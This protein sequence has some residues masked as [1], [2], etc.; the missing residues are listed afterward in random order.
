VVF[1]FFWNFSP[2][3]GY[4]ERSYLIDVRHFSPTSF[5]IILA[6]GSLAFLVSIVVYRWVVRRFRGVAWYHYLY[7]TVAVGVLAFPASFFLYLDPDHPWWRVVWWLLPDQLDV[8]TG[9]NRYAWC[10]LLTQ[11]ILGFATIPAFLI[12]LTLAGETVKVERAGVSYALLMSLTNV[13]NMFE[14]VVGAGLYKLLTQPGMDG[15]LTAFRGSLFDIAQVNDE[16]TI[17]LQ[18]FV[19]I[20]LTF[21]ALTLPFIALLRHE[22]A[23]RG[24]TID[25]A[26]RGSEAR[27][28]C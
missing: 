16:R 6:A 7:A 10:R 28:V 18:I 4:I 17:I 21:T 2:S 1:L 14:G 22:F 11:L 26:G 12:P 27:T 25:L 5:G 8:I 15:L 9:W 23:R 20:S 3:I 19:Y 13:T 24:L